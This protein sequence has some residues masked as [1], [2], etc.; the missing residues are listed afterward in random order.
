M[1]KVLALFAAAILFL[2]AAAQTS[3]GKYVMFPDNGLIGAMWKPQM[4]F[5]RL[6]DHD[7]L[8]IRSSAVDT[9]YSF[10]ED[11]R[12]LLR[13]ADSTVVKL[14][15]I[16]TLEV[17]K[18]YKAHVTSGIVTDEYITYSFYEIDED[19]LGKIVVEQTPIVKVR[20]AYANGTVRDYD[21]KK[22][23]QK[24]FIKGLSES[25]Q[26]AVSDNAIRQKNATDEDF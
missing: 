20:L 11:S 21:I 15:I 9:Y 26:K 17:E 7:V 18:D 6:D 22:S 23:Y 25:Y 16:P 19:I 4:N 13:F 3:F 12:V 10:D 24:K 1:K 5:G 2:Q 14:S 8:V